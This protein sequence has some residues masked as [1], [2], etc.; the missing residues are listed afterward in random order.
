MLCLQVD[1]PNT[2][3]TLHLW[4]KLDTQCLSDCLSPWLTKSTN[5]SFDWVA[6]LT[7]QVIVTLLGIDFWHA[8]GQW[9]VIVVQ[10]A[11][12]CKH[13][14]STWDYIHIIIISCHSRL[15]MIT[16]YNSHVIMLTMFLAWTFALAST[17]ILTTSVWPPK[18]ALC[19]TVSPS[20]VSVI[21]WNVHVATYIRTFIK[22]FNTFKQLFSTSNL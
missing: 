10:H 8:N 20:Y 11:F 12:I 7:L 2:F 5:L 1:V 19:K 18:A 9:E 6:I 17:N 14:L 21:I 3:E 16:S 15:N 13:L 22:I 4:K